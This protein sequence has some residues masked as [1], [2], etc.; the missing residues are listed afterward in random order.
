V[1]HLEHLFQCL[2][3]DIGQRPLQRLKGLCGTLEIVEVAHV[4]V[5]NHG[6]DLSVNGR[7][8]GE[9]EPLRVCVGA[10]VSV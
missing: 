5:G 6:G 10:C 7:N 3:R 2:G 9:C 8:L 4:G 1:T